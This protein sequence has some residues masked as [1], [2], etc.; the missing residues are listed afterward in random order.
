[1]RRP[2]GE[3]VG[4]V[5]LAAVSAGTCNFLDVHLA[6]GL[7]IHRVEP[8]TLVALRDDPLDHAPVPDETSE[9]TPCRHVSLAR[10][11]K[12]AQAGLSEPFK[13]LRS[14]TDVPGPG[15]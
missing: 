5:R 15:R 1:V 4:F 9:P 13:L 8:G 2:N 10:D 6:D 11:P 7:F 12:D 3:L 14:G